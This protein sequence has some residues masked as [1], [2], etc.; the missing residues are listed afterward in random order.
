MPGSVFVSTRARP[1]NKQF[2]GFA[3]LASFLFPGAGQIMCGRF[4]A[5]LLVLFGFILTLAAGAF[6]W[7]LLVLPFFIW[8]WGVIDAYHSGSKV[9]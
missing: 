5:G 6:I 8:L 2:G 9:R 7:P 4:D 3:A 1:R